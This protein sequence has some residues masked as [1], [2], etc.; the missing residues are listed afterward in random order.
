MLILYKMLYT[1]ITYSSTTTMLIYQ[2]KPYETK[3]KVIAYDMD[4]CTMLPI[5]LNHDAKVNKW[6]SLPS[7]MIRITPT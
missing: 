2:Q 3:C 1:H 7:T 4:H 5:Y 6:L